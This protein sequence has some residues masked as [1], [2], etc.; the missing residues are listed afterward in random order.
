[1]MLQCQPQSPLPIIWTS[2]LAL[3]FL[4]TLSSFL[5]SSPVDIHNVCKIQPAHVSQYKI[6]LTIQ[7]LS[8]GTKLNSAAMSKR[9]TVKTCTL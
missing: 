5:P 2:N 1:M 3:P 9:F 8:G 4:K 7:L 6:L